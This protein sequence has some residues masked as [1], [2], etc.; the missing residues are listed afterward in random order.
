M[1]KYKAGDKVVLTVSDVN[2]K[3]YY[4][5]Y[6]FN[7]NNSNLWISSTDKYSEPLSTYTE[8][9]EDTI[10]KHTVKIARLVMEKER[11]KDENERLKAE[12][13]KMSAKI[14]AY[15]L[16]GGQHEEEYNQTFNKGAEEAWELARK[17]TCQPIN[18]GFKRSEFEEI[19]NEGYISDVFVK[20]TYPE[21]TA[22]VAEWEKAKEEIK[23]GDILEN[24]ADR[25]IKCVATNLYPNNMAYL[26]FSDGSA[27]MNKLDNFKKTGRHIDID[28]FLKQIGGKQE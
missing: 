1:S 15:E 21:A 17:I 13:K 9:L 24:I 26:V 6:M 5:Y 28:G 16:Y 23:A 8:P 2:E 19:F 3:A 11:L 7:N 20:Y 22:K 10:Q 4:P 27:G 25:S 14:D 12:N 18:G